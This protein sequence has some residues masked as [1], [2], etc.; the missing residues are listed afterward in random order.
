MNKLDENNHPMHAA[1]FAVAGAVLAKIA[2]YD[3]TNQI[4]GY[5]LLSGGA[6]LAY[7]QKY[8]HA[9]PGSNADNGVATF[10]EEM[11]PT[12]DDPDPTDL[13]PAHQAETTK[14]IPP[15]SVENDA[16][17]AKAQREQDRLDRLAAEA[18]AAA[19]KK[20][21]EDAARAQ[22]EYQGNMFRGITENPNPVIVTDVPRSGYA[23][24]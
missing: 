1:G 21:K 5:G 22:L 3:D 11:G 9:L 2:G 24:M 12:N 23:L 17:F 13:T 15:P 19:E 20:R 18:A 16:A 4:L 10:G 7:M 14:L 8:G 6:S